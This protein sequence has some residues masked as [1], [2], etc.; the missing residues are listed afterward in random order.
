LNR[1]HERRQ[2]YKSDMEYKRCVA[3]SRT[4]VKTKI[5]D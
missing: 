3:E 5:R 2:K 1:H 4:I